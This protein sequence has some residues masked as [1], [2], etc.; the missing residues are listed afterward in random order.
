MRARGA[1]ISSLSSHLISAS[2][3]LPPSNPQS[4][5]SPCKKARGRRPR[6]WGEGRTDGGGVSGIS[7]RFDR[8]EPGKPQSRTMRSRATLARSLAPSRS[9]AHSET[10]PF[11]RRLL[12]RLLVCLRIAVGKIKGPNA[13]PSPPVPS[14]PRT[15]MET[16][17]T[18]ANRDAIPSL[19]E[20]STTILIFE[21]KQES[22]PAEEPF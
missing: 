14:P 7:I 6:A 19:H 22:A 16:V 15:R 9:L 11:S 10:S 21:P 12:G 4:F 2:L 20:G 5:V 13:I 8:R 17:D 1:G 3:P 18:E